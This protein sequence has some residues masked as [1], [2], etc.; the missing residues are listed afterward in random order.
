MGAVFA[1][2]YSFPNEVVTGDA[3]VRYVAGDVVDGPKVMALN[4]SSYD[5]WYFDAVST[6]SNASVVI[7]LYRATPGGFPLVLKGSSSSVN[8]FITMDNGTSHYF[9]IANRPGRSGEVVVSTDGQGASGVWESTGFSFFGSPDLSHYTVHINS[10]AHRFNGTLSLSAAAPAHYPCGLSRPGEDLHISPHVGW[11]NAIPDANAV[12]TFRVRGSDIHFTGV[13][14]HDKNWGDQRFDQ[15]VRTWYWGHGR[16]GPY[17][18]VWFDTVQLDGSR[19]VS[20]YVARDGRVVQS[21]CDTSGIQVLPNKSGASLSGNGST[22]SGFS[23][24]M[25][26]EEGSLRVQAD[27]VASS[28]QSPVYYRWLGSLSGGIVGKAQYNGVGM[29]EEFDF[30][31]A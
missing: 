27:N 11:A 18:L 10:P 31:E 3:P 5:W 21:S 25:E 9:P 6:T 29:W 12:G 19:Y 22:L 24:A 26:L 17:S 13:G 14:Y 8:L 28:A 30:T 16:L 7:V 4:G 23:I 1:E 2:L 20:A 15:H